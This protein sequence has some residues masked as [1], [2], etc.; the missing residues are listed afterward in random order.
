MNIKSIGKYTIFSDVHWK[1]IYHHSNNRM[2]QI[3]RKTDATYLSYVDTHLMRTIKEFK[4]FLKEFR[5]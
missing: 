1:Q 4:T 2:L 3:S 5:K